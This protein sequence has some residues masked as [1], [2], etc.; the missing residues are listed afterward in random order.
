MKISTL[1]VSHNSI[2]GGCFSLAAKII[3]ADI[4]TFGSAIDYFEIRPHF[5]GTHNLTTGGEESY[6]AYRQS[7]KDLPSFTFSRVLRPL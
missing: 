7:L 6:A 2:S 1:T 4:P 5:D 3:K